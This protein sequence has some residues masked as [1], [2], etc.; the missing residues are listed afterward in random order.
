VDASGETSSKKSIDRWQS[1]VHVCRRWRSIVFESPRRLNLRL[2]CTPRT[3]VRDALDIWPPLPLLIW[4]KSAQP[5]ESVDKIIAAI[6][7]VNLVR[8]IDLRDTPSSHLET[9]SAGMQ[10]PFPELTVLV[11]DSKDETVPVLPD[12]FL[13]GYAPCLEHLQFGRVPFPSL[14]KLLLSATNLAY[15]RLYD[16]PHSGYFPPE[17]LATALSTSTNLSI[18][19]LF[20]QSPQSR[21]DPESRCPPP[22]TRSVLPNLIYFLFKG[23]SEYLEEIVARIDTPRLNNLSIGFFNQILFDT[24]QFIQFISRTPKFKAV[25]GARL[26]FEND[27]AKAEL[28]SQTPGSGLLNVDIPCTDVDWQIS[29]LEQICSACLPPLSTLEVL[30]ISEGRYSHLIWPDDIENTLWLE[31]LRPFASAKNLHLSGQVTPRIMPALQ[32]LVGAR[33]TEVLPAL[34]NIFLEELQLSGPVQEGVER[35]A[36]TRQAA[37]HPIAVS[38]WENRGRF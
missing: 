31:L 12:S 30:Y 26:F 19:L 20:F 27:H 33:T 22:L 5:T 25:K 16:I 23:V 37:G 2:G 34:Q 6:E 13:G 15:L 3:P 17:A 32:E 8:Q 21:P 10:V 28:F 4:S 24:P 35:F 38:R 1:L 9:V 7:R 36:A 11:L 14:P 29:S 18:L